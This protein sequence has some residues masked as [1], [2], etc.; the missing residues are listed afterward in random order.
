MLKNQL[1]LDRVKLKGL[2]HN[3]DLIQKKQLE[4]RPWEHVLLVLSFFG[5]KS[6]NNFLIIEYHSDNSFYIKIIIK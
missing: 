5:V 2:L 4:N 3:N 6:E 1:N